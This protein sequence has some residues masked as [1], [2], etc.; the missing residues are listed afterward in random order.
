MKRN[1]TIGFLVLVLAIVGVVL[2]F[3]ANLGDVV[4]TAVEKGG[5]AATQ[6]SV[7]LAKAEVKPTEGSATLSGLV[8]GNPP[9]FKTDNAF[10][11]GGISVKIDPATVTKDVVIVK[12]VVV[13]GPK[14]TYEL[15]ANGSNIDA[16]KKNVERFAGGGG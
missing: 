4:K 11:L 15:G 10:E 7:T 5:S 14:V 8:V 2:Y 12:E 1:L 3:L 13:Q 9:G 16:I 6:V